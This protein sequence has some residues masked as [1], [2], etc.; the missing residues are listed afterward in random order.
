[1]FVVLAIAFVVPFQIEFPRKPAKCPPQQS[2]LSSLNAHASA[3]AS[4]LLLSMHIPVHG[5]CCHEVEHC[6]CCISGCAR[7][8][9]PHIFMSCQ[10]CDE[11]VFRGDTCSESASYQMCLWRWRAHGEVGSHVSTCLPVSLLLSPPEPLQLFDCLLSDAGRFV[12]GANW[13]L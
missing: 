3:N 4:A 5:F 2:L 1:M 8:C 10:L 11:K 9:A 13:V 6:L 12:T 7:V